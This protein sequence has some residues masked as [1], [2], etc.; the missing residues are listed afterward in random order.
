MYDNRI[1]S[2][3]AYVVTSV[4]KS[5]ADN[6][7]TKR[8]Y[9]KKTVSNSKKKNDSDS[10]DDNLHS[11]TPHNSLNDNSATFSNELENRLRLQSEENARLAQAK[12]NQNTLNDSK[13]SSNSNCN[14]NKSI[15][16]IELHNKLSQAM[17]V[18]VDTSTLSKKIE[19]LNS[20]RN[21]SNN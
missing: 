15:A 16:E 17:Q 1:I 3:S 13:S 12:F 19:L 2:D 21:E 20:L 10:F 18:E 11:A 5:T 8:P 4:A 7:I 6:R 9:T 14:S